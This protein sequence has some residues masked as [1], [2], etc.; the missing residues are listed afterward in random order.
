M[1]VLGNIFAFVLIMAAS[2]A[3]AML[4]GV[5]LSDLWEWFVVPL[6]PPP[7]TTV[8]AI[9]LLWVFFI[10]SMRLKRESRDK[11]PGDEWWAESIFS[12]A[13]SVFGYLTCWAFGAI[14]HQFM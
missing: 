6:G 11:K 10:F 2:F 9:G 1:K 7:I 4:G 5:V 12:L 13:Y 8:H 3:S 14:W